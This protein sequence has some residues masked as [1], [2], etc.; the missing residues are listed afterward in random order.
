LPRSF[1]DTVILRSAV[2]DAYPESRL[3]DALADVIHRTLFG[4]RTEVNA[5]PPARRRPPTLDFGPV[6]RGTLQSVDVRPTLNAAGRRALRALIDA[7]RDVFVARGYHGT[8]V[9]DIVRAAGVSHGAFYHY[10][11]SKDQFA[12]VL[13]A[14]AMRRVSTAFADVP[15]STGPWDAARRAALR[16]W[17]RR[18]NT[19]Q[20]TE[21]AMVRV[22][23][24]AARHDPS[25][26]ADSAAALDW[27]RRL[28]ARFLAPREFG[29]V[30]TEALVM[31][32]LLATFG[33]RGRSA[34]TIEAATHIIERGFFGQ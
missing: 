6:M 34:P 28:M 31:V 29:D 14:R 15:D 13:A 20:A 17:L 12:H 18:F 16:R 19:V 7:G 25:L 1:E 27:G 26:S 9:D 4:L 22:W 8:R 3:E 32:A 30:D 21:A 24:D 33:T 10:F 5:H 23:V 11:E 2:P